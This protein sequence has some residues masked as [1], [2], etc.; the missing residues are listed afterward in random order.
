[1]PKETGIGWEFSRTQYG[2]AGSAH[3]LKAGETATIEVAPPRGAARWRLQ[4]RYRPRGALARD[5]YIKSE[6]IIE[7]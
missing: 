3:D 4:V 6:E 7:R 5:A 2:G 1:V